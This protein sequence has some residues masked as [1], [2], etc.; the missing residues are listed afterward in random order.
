MVGALVVTYVWR[1]HTFAPVL[2]PFRVATLATLASWGFLIFQ[3]R[4]GRIAQ[5]LRIPYVLLFVLWSVWMTMGGFVALNSQLAWDHIIGGQLQALTALLFTLGF[6]STMKEVR[7]VVM[8][9]LV[10]CA[11][12]VF[13]YTKQGFPGDWTPVPMYDPN[14]LATLLAM[15][16]PLMGYLA[17]EAHTA[18]KRRLLGLFTGYVALVCLLTQSRGGFLAIAGVALFIFLQHNGIRLRTR[19]A[20]PAMFGLGLIFAPQEVKNELVT[21]TALDEDYNMET[22]TGRKAIWTRGLT[23]IQAYPVFGVGAQNFGYADATLPPEAAQ[24]WWRG[25]APHNSFIQVATDT[26]IPGLAL[27]LGMLLSCAYRMYRIRQKFAKSRDPVERRF[28]SFAT[29]CIASI[30]GYCLGGF[31]LS[32]AYSSMLVFHIAL[33]AGLEI[34][35]RNHRRAKATVPA[36]PRVMHGSKRP[37]LA[38]AYTVRN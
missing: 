26:G 24:P 5:G 38:G 2:A 30:I 28:G 35:V 1:F 15:T 18:K 6:F 13:F 14:D 23:Y 8:A 20:I 36:R 29:L 32:Q 37:V 25:K 11:A 17:L 22:S 27:F 34:A 19:V 12:M 9:H 31:L 10:G 16:A 4:S 3:S 21:L 33:A 7:F